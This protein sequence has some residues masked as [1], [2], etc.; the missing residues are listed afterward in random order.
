MI[1]P[2]WIDTITSS[3]YDFYSSDS[4][5]VTK[6]NGCFI[7]ETDCA[8]YGGSVSDAYAY[9]SYESFESYSSGGTLVDD[10]SDMSNLPLDAD[11]NDS[12]SDD[13]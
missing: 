4:D 13:G 6:G 1:E 3:P 2:T 10:D 9:D 12:D 8:T 7:Y 5:R 11:S